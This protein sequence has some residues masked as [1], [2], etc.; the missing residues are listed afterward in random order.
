MKRIII[1]LC[2]VNIY[3]LAQDNNQVELPDFVIIGKRKAQL[4]A[5]EKI[6]PLGSVFT[7]DY[8]K[9]AIPL[10]QHKITDFKNLSIELQ[11]D[12]LGNNFNNR[13]DFGLGFF[14]WPQI[15]LFI[16]KTYKNSYLITKLFGNNEREYVDK[17]GV[18]ELNILAKY[19][20]FVPNDYDFLPGSQLLFSAQYDR[21][22][23]N[24]F[25]SKYNDVKD[26]SRTIHNFD[27]NAGWDHKYYDNFQFLFNVNQ[28]L[29]FINNIKNKSYE[30]NLI[31]DFSPSF[32]FSDITVNNNLYY[33]ATSFYEKDS[34]I[35]DNT[36]LNNN[37]YLSYDIDQNISLYGGAFISKSKETKLF[38]KPH[39][40]LTWKVLEKTWLR[41]NYIPTQ[42]L[43]TS[44]DLLD[45]NLYYS[46]N[47]KSTLLT[48]SS[49]LNFSIDYQYY[50]FLQNLLTFS[51]NNYFNYPIFKYYDSLA[52]YDVE[53]ISA[54]QFAIEN[55]TLYN[56]DYY[57]IFT[58][59][60]MFNFIK[61]KDGK[62]IPYTPIFNMNIFYNYQLFKDF[63]IE[64]NLNI[65]YKVYSDTSFT[66]SK[67]FASLG[68]KLYY[69]L[70]KN[71]N[72]YVNFNNVTN[73][74]NYYYYFYRMKKFEII[75]G[76]TYSW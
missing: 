9:P 23:T 72:F 20:L 46:L 4:P 1:I 56:T 49:S 66:K 16:S 7:D 63:Y 22:I 31:F 42:K 38:A 26:K 5:K 59:K 69:N 67:N 10:S 21:K 24:F 28:N 43:L 54:K 14:T 29:L 39:L 74:E 53:N 8:L 48:L 45:K 75:G 61:T 51:I 71:L 64:P 57:G 70:T 18:N 36:L 47:R 25:A 33:Q 41:V 40:G 73:K 13:L 76:L 15:D 50:N 34:V 3:L 17:S 52:I 11:R 2:I 37:F 32:K 58:F 55:T 68:L 35:A 60:F 19:N 44:K 62:K 27:L 6:K 65:N 30:N 12:Q